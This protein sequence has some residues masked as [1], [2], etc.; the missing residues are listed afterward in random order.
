[1]VFGEGEDKEDFETEVSKLDSL[2]IRRTSKHV[3]RDKFFQLK[4]EGQTIYQFVGV[5]RKQVKDCDFG[6]LK[7]DLMLHVLIR[8]LESDQIRRRLFKTDKL[9]L[10]KVVQM[11][12]AMEATSADLQAW[13][14]KKSEVQEDVAVVKNGVQTKD[15][16]SDQVA[17]VHGRQDLRKNRPSMWVLE[18]KES[19]MKGREMEECTKCGRSH[20][21]RQCP[22]FRQTYHKCG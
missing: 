11:C 17:A 7:D 2:C 6:M 16:G 1:M 22:A 5:L 15:D 21:P 13:S 3:L 10:A 8:G 18:V 12:Q 9:E 20:R 4:Q 19:P 14:D